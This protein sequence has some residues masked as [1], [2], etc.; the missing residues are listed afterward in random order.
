METPLNP[1]SLS[2]K[3]CLITGATRGIGLASARLFAENGATVALVGRNQSELER[4]ASELDAMAGR[5]CASTF[6]CDVSDDTAVRE[7]FQA[8]FRQYRRL[9]V[10]LSNA[11]VLDDA[12][13]GM[14]TRGQIQRVF[15]TN[16][17]GLLYCAQ[18]ASRLMARSGG[19]SIINVASIIGANGNAGQAVYGGS[20]AAVIGIT[21]S[22]AKELAPNQIR[23]NAIAP[24]FIDTAM[25]RGL[26]P[27]K[28]EQRLASIAMG[29]IG[30]PD[31]VARTALFLASDLSA[32]VTGQCIGVDGG[33]LI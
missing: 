26:P 29:R 16:T 8:V 4:H 12:L 7:L 11:G 17:F 31:D 3:I 33:M 25:T 22:L 27:A 18:Y 15:G 6:V 28:F 24:G 1:T 9:D 13:L 20:K 32:Y 21:K 10:L 23:V 5:P 2:G 30:T 14:I 19:G